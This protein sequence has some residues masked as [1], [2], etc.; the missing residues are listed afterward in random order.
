MQRE[1]LGNQRG[2]MGKWAPIEDG[3]GAGGLRMSREWAQSILIGRGGSE[4]MGQANAKHGARG[5]I[6]IRNI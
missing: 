2:E 5:P 1:D 3:G 6:D 4:W